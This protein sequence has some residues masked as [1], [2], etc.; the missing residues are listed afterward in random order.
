ME[1]RQSS[2]TRALKRWLNRQ[3][4]YLENAPPG[5]LVCATV[6]DGMRLQGII[7]IGR[8]RARGLPQD[9]SVGEIT[10]LWL[11]DGLP[12]GTASALILFAFDLCRARGGMKRVISYHDRTRHTGCI[13]RKAG[14]RKNGVANPLANGWASRLR[15]ELPLFGIIEERVS[16]ALEGTPKRRWVIDL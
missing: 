11:E 2:Y 10:C 15:R 9:G 7:L 4:H 6:G 3:S 5:C 1:F 13:Y 12:R 16:G 8:P 14:M